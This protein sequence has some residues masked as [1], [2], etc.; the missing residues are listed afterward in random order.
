MKMGGSKIGAL[1]RRAGGTVRTIVLGALLSLSALSSVILL[2]WLMTLMR[3]R[4]LVVAGQVLTG[5]DQPRWLYG[6]FDAAWPKRFAGGLGRNIARG[7]AAAASLAVA[8]FPFAVL[9]LASWWAGWENSFNKGY[10]QALAGQLVGL[11]GIAIFVVVMVYLPMALVHQ[12][13]EQ[14]AFSFFELRRVGSVVAHTGPA[15]IL[16]SGAS[17]LLAVP[18][19]LSRILPAFAEGFYPG[20]ANFS[21][22]QVAGTA[23]M[24]KLFVALY[25][26]VTL[27]FLKRWSAGI[28]ARAVQRASTS[29]DAALWQGS[30]LVEGTTYSSGKSPWRVARLARFMVLSVIWAGLA[31]LIF[32]GQFVNHGLHVWLSHPFIFLPWGM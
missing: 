22:E 7:T 31:V 20:L 30:A 29:A 5:H 10:E 28:Y 21:P 16:W 18:F 3:S 32:V 11:A 23:T 1:L 14:R 19:F 25:L 17:V 12:A 4:A 6:A 15:Y 13:V 26:F 24:I 8:T 27:V 2:G 9:W